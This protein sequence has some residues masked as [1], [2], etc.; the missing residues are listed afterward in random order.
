MEIFIIATILEVLA[1]VRSAAKALVAVTEETVDGAMAAVVREAVFV[2][3]AAVGL[4]VDE[5]LIL[6]LVAVDIVG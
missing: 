4:V 1:Q 6:M 3:A 2:Q 5:N